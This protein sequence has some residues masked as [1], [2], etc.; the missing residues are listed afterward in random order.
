MPWLPKQTHAPLLPSGISNWALDPAKMNRGLYVT[1]QPPTIDELTKT[2]VKI[3]AASV[4]NIFEIRKVAGFIR[5]IAQKKG[6]N[7]ACPLLLHWNSK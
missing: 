2:A 5:K 7:S 1:R 4:R 3:I 6:R